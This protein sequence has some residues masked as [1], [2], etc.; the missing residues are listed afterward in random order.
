M[1]KVLDSTLRE[2]EQTPGVYFDGHIKL[3]ISDLLDAIGV[4]IIE[5]GQKI[6]FPSLPG[7][8]RKGTYTVH[9]ASFKPF[10]Y[11]RD[12]FEDLMLKGYEAYIMPAFNTQ[13]GK[14]YRVTLGSFKS[15]N[16]AKIYAAAIVRKGI[17][18][19]GDP[20]RLDMI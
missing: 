1:I 6:E 8:S 10:E 18:E 2:G 7:H 20:I 17:S 13:Q 3:A 9:I 5:V 11:A 4:D 12:L 16:E 19:Y 15:H 14:I